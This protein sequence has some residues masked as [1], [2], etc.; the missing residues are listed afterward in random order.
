MMMDG[1][2]SRG[3]MGRLRDRRGVAAPLH[4]DADAGPLGQSREEDGA[5]GKPCG[6][7]RLATGRRTCGKCATPPLPF[8]G[9]ASAEVRMRAE[10]DA[11]APLCEGPLFPASLLLDAWCATGIWAH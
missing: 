3:N 11:L 10:I 4:T 6:S 7:Q 5:A 2:A 1:W 8:P 9:C